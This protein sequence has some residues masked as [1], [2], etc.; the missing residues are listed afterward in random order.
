MPNEL[1]LPPELLHLIEK[2][3]GKERR[4]EKRTETGDGQPPETDASVDDTAANRRGGKERR[5]QSP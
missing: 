2:R 5:D 4:S 3:E 1:P